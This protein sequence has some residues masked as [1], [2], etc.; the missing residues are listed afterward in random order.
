MKGCVRE[1]PCAVSRVKSHIVTGVRKVCHTKY[2]NSTNTRTLLFHFSVY[3]SLC[4]TATLETAR[5]RP[6][7]LSSLVE[8]VLFYF[9]FMFLVERNGTWSNPVHPHT[10]ACYKKKI[11]ALWHKLLT[12][13]L[14][15]P[16][17]SPKSTLFR[18]DTDIPVLNF[19]LMSAAKINTKPFLWQEPKLHCSMTIYEKYMSWALFWG[20]LLCRLLYVLW[21]HMSGPLTWKLC[22]S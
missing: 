12:W 3:E 2:I 1:I 4:L 8:P 5:E 9:R 22:E 11:K 19:T 15:I 10:Q 6:G 21:R 17:V 7:D 20:C 16:V 18:R 14:I 13:S